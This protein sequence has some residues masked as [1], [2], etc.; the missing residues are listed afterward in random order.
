[1]S[2]PTATHPSGS[3]IPLDGLHIQ[4]DAQTG[5][6]RNSQV[7]TFCSD[8]LPGHFIPQEGTFLD[9]KFRKGGVDG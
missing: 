3:S 5:L 9:H 6:L 2:R 7:S 4:L 1:M 8:G